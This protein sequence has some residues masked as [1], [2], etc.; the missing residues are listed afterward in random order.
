MPDWI[1]PTILLT[2]TGIA[3]LM[4]FA[5]V[6]SETAERRTAAYK[7][8]LILLPSGLLIVSAEF[9]MTHFTPGT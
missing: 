2:Y 5:A 4:V 8:L 1:P 3:A 6:F 9:A 7:V